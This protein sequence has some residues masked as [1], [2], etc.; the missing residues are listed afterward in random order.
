[1]TADVTIDM[2]LYLQVC[3]YV[4]EM[5]LVFND[6]TI[7][8]A[9]N[10]K[11]G[12][13]GCSVLR[14]VLHSPRR[15]CKAY[16]P[17]AV[18]VFPEG[19]GL[20]EVREPQYCDRQEQDHHVLPTPP[21]QQ[22]IGPIEIEIRRPPSG[23]LIHRFTSHVG[24]YPRVRGIPTDKAM[25]ILYEKQDRRCNGCFVPKPFVELT[26]DH[27]VPKS[28]SGPRTIENAELMCASWNKDKDNEVMAT[29]LA[30][31]WGRVLWENAETKEKEGAWDQGPLM[32]MHFGR[33][34]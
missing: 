23:R 7:F 29:F 22:Q 20:R 30:K 8:T 26:Y 15:W 17:S 33:P 1:M 4:A 3:S 27:R 31:K 19:T 12:A 14:H 6:R 13:C 11:C 25:H 2:R 16:C 5:S 34:I 24:T 10:G 18:M 21:G 28:K 9:M 32:T